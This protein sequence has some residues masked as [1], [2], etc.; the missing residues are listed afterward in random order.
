MFFIKSPDQK[1]KLEVY[2]RRHFDGEFKSEYEY[3]GVMDMEKC[4]ISNGPVEKGIQAIKL[5]E[6]GDRGD[7]YYISAKKAE[8]ITKLKTF[9]EIVKDNLLPN[10]HDNNNHDFVLTTFHEATTCTVCGK[11]LRGL[12]SQGYRCKKTQKIVHKECLSK[13]TAP[14]NTFCKS[15]AP[16]QRSPAPQPQPPQ[17]KSNRPN[18][19]AAAQPVEPPRIRRPAPDPNNY[20]NSDPRSHVWFSTASSRQEA[21]KILKNMPD[22]TFLVRWS[23]EQK[24]YVIS[25]KCE[26]LRH[27]KINETERREYNLKPAIS[28]KNVPD[29][30]VYYRA[31]S[32][33]EIFP[34]IT[35]PL[36]QVYSEVKGDLVK[37]K[38][39]CRAIYNFSASGADQLSFEEGDVIEIISKREN[40]GWWKGM[41]RDKAIFQIITSKRCNDEDDDS[42]DDD[43]D[44]E[45]DQDDDEKDQDDEEQDD[46]DGDDEEN[47][48]EDD[49]EDDDGGEEEEQKVGNGVADEDGDGHED[50]DEKNGGDEVM[51]III[52]I[53]ILLY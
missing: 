40:C 3:K 12:L 53:Y 41:L 39:L 2:G 6:S 9:L 20:R 19:V 11:L 13:A 35:M 5:S 24:R 51:I 8:Q 46:G 17:S 52:R 26:T 7:V 14:A 48:D 25:M 23:E 42:K 37:K 4:T 49:D 18:V 31:N 29:L 32:L 33:H 10:G 36:K 34:N 28:F 21:N 45:D 43:G 38:Q 47:D 30:I 50:D 1:C 22:G 44:R 27:I 16:N 15:A